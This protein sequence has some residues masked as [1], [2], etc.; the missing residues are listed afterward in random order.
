M[1]HPDGTRPIVL[2]PPTFP[3]TRYVDPASGEA[4]ADPVDDNLSARHL[5]TLL[6]L[7]ADALLATVQ[8]KATTTADMEVDASETASEADTSKPDASAPSVP[9]VLGHLGAAF[10]EADSLVQLLSVMRNGKQVQPMPR[11]AL[12]SKPAATP[13]PA[14]RAFLKRQQLDDAAVALQRGAKALRARNERAVCA[15]DEAKTLRAHWKLLALESL[16]A[17]RV[18]RASAA[19]VGRDDRQYLLRLALASATAVTSTASAAAAAQTQ[20]IV[21][22]SEAASSAAASMA[23]EMVLRSDAHGSLRMPAAS[24][25]IELLRVAGPNED[26]ALCAPLPFGVSDHR[27]RAATDVDGDEAMAATDGGGAGMERA[28]AV[29]GGARRCHRQLLGAHFALCARAMYAQVAEE[30]RSLPHGALLR[31]ETSRVVVECANVPERCIE[32]GLRSA[33]DAGDADHEADSAQPTAGTNERGLNAVEVAMFARW[34]RSRASSDGHGGALRGGG[35]GS[36]AAQAALLPYA[37]GACSLDAMHGRLRASLDEIAATWC[38][39]RLQCHWEYGSDGG[40]GAP[41]D[42]PL[43]VYVELRILCGVEVAS[44]LGVRLTADS[45]H[46]QYI[47]GLARS[48]EALAVFPMAA[49]RAV[50]DAD[51]GVACLS[52]LVHAALGR[53]LLL[54]V[55]RRAVAAGLHGHLSLHATRLMVHAPTTGTDVPV[56]AGS[57]L[58]ALGEASPQPG[59]PAWVCVTLAPAPTPMQAELCV[60]DG[61]PRLIALRE[62]RGTGELAKVVGLVAREVLARGSTR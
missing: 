33:D 40:T 19:V 2:E 9:V 51:D 25:R 45:V 8:E 7:S 53:T 22:A 41:A 34:E 28:E 38:E 46:A 18:A 55:Q 43:S 50:G 13:P 27:A 35:G 52:E 21:S 37:L 26:P 14:L 20:T 23:H 30:A 48:S 4:Q 47:G 62:M 61:A 44:A 56:D 49:V 5:K 3:A 16:P 42:A 36:S 54:R 32:V 10:R 57:A 59:T 15:H 39:P 6:T 24:A 31:A 11:V 58:D 29:G 17:P 1:A 60:G 12:P